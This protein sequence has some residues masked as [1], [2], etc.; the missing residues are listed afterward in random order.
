MRTISRV[1]VSCVILV[2]CA[3]I[4][5][6]RDDDSDDGGD[7]AGGGGG[8]D[9]DEAPWTVTVDMSATDRFVLDAPA[10]WPVR[11][12][13][14]ASLGLADVTVDGHAA[15]VEPSGA[16]TA[17]VTPTPGL[18]VVSVVA[19]DAAG[20]VRQAHR[21]LLQASFLPEGT[22]AR[23]AAGVA[24]TDAVLAGMSSSLTETAGDV[25]VASEIMMRETLSSDDRCTTWPVH[26]TQD[27]TT[28][29]LGLDGTELLV[30]IHVPNLYVYFEGACSGLLSEIPIAGEM[31]MDI[32][33][34]TQIAP[35][36]ASECLEGFDHTP[37]EVTLP[38]FSFDVWATGGP[39]EA[40]L[41]ELGSSGKAEEAH[42]RLQGE[43]AGQADE[44]LQ[45]KLAD[46]R[47]FDRQQTMTLLAQEVELA[48]CV[49]RIEPEGSQLVARVGAVVHGTGQRLAPGAPQVGGPLAVPQSGELLLDADLVAQLLFSAWRMGGLQRARAQTADFGLLALLAPGLVDRYPNATEVDVNIDGELPPVVRTSTAAGA[50]LTV[51]LGDLML[52]L[53]I[54]DDRLFRLGVSLRLELDLV[55]MD[56]A[57]VPTVVGADAEARLLDEIEDVAD[58][59]L[60]LAVQAKLG[61]SVA[62]LLGDAKLT[63]PALPGLGAPTDV[64]PDPAGR[65]LRIATQ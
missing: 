44:K 16:F 4:G 54:G 42:D 60:E 49:T 22:I 61:S 64:T 28:A 17:V 14:V 25:D 52:D 58:G 57:L 31:F 27:S 5:Q 19:T 21:T 26:A 11:G 6:P 32:D 29:T 41:V 24:L 46:M 10:T 47:V 8:G 7:G 34:W 62:D 39:F 45:S 38:G 43:L 63:L 35:K 36:A 55:P 40:W 20:H 56:G 51:E 18:A 3:N 59:A 33:I 50:D 2:S 53:A 65:F 23:F 12:Q 30:N 1:F 9:G 15:P 37:P 48:L 13:A